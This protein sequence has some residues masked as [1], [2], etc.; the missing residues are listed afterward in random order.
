MCRCGN[1]RSVFTRYILQ[2]SGRHEAIALGFK[3][4]T[5]ETIALLC[6]WADRILLA[7]LDMQYS[8]LSKYQEKIDDRFFIG[9]DI[10]PEN[11]EGELK[12]IVIDK[13]KVLEYI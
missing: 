5:P 10:Y 12:D 9:P 8:I 4:N 13:L 11:I 3:Y 2:G 1:K 7:E 6:K